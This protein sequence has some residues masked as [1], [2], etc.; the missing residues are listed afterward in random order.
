MKIRYFF[1]INT[2]E[3][4]HFL[5]LSMVN[6]VMP[7]KFLSLSCIFSPSSR[8]EDEVFLRV[9]GISR[10]HFGDKP[11]RISNSIASRKKGNHH[12]CQNGNYFRGLN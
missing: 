8:K 1:S 3:E 7:Q 4:I 6:Y 2:I 12:N 5:L 9:M 10:V 11:R